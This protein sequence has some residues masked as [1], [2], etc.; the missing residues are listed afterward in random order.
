MDGVAAF[1]DAVL[2]VRVIADVHIVEDDGILDGYVV[3]D[4]H[5]LEENGVLDDAVD[6]AAGS[7][8]AVAHRSVRVVFGGR[9]V[10][11]LGVHVRILAEEVVA[12]VAVQEIHVGAEVV[13]HGCD[14]APVAFHHIGAD[15]LAGLVAHQDAAHEVEVVVRDAALQ[16]FN[17]EAATDDVNAG[18]NQPILRLQRLLLELDDAVFAVELDRAEAGVVTA[19]GKVRHNHRN[20]RLRVDVAVDNKV[21][22]KLINAVARSDNH[23]GLMAVA[24]EVKVLI[25]GISRAAVPE[26]V[27]LGDG[28]C[29][30]VQTALLAAEVPP[31]RRIQVLVQGARAVLRQNR[32]L[33]D[34]R[35]RHVRKGKVDASVAA[36]NGHCRDG[37]ATGQFLHAVRITAG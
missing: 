17:Q 35:V 23:V 16:K 12:D 19:F 13:F 15:A 14:V 31:L 33:L 34:V 20:V 36:G 29:E 11:H 8:E 27:L 30:E 7:D 24:Q 9:K 4:V 2:D 22:I 32:N 18:G 25:H 1:D 37:T 28:R 6:D 5:L 21:V 3:S 10:V 26:A